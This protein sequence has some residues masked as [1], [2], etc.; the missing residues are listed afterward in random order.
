[1][2]ESSRSVGY[3]EEF[4]VWADTE[5][6][7][8]SNM[9]PCGRFDKRHYLFKW[10]F[11]K[12]LRSR[13]GHVKYYVFLDADSYFVRNPGDIL[14]QLKGAPVH[15]CMESECSSP[16]NI[17]PD[18]WGCP[19]PKYVE[20]MRNMGVVGPVYNT[21]AG[22]WIVHRDAVDRVVEL[23]F[24]Y[25]EAGRD[26]GYTF[27]E[28]APLAYVGHMLMGD[29]SRHTLRSN[30]DCWASDWTGEFAGRLPEDRTWRFTDYMSGETFPVRPAIV[31]AMRS[32]EAMIAAS[33]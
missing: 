10:R 4:Y 23:A 18:W 21:N 14:E 33:N 30:P 12:E 27:T 15:V 16:S 19:L 13:V 24:E 22:F 5:R 9:L 3:R 8:N 29:P 26:A 1:M 6:I 17:R 20:L 32:K 7:A 2:V 11:L 28:E 31:H 25:W